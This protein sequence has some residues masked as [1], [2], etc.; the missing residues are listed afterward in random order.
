MKWLLTMVV[1]IVS[2]GIAVPRVAVCE[3]PAREALRYLAGTWEGKVAGE[4][5]QA[6]EPGIWEGLCITERRNRRR[7]ASQYSK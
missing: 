2:A 4:E 7:A 6:Q 3:E 1:A 5:S